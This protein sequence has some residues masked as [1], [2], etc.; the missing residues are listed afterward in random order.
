MTGYGIKTWKSIAFPGILFISLAAFLFADAIHQKLDL[1]SWIKESARI[2]VMPAEDA[3]QDTFTQALSQL[4]AMGAENGSY[5]Y[6]IDTNLQTQSVDKDISVRGISAAMIEGTV[7]S[8]EYY[9]DE[10]SALSAVI[11]IP[12]LATI[13]GAD[14]KS[15]QQSELKQEAAQWI[16]H[17]LIIGKSATKISCVVDDSSESEAVFISIPA[18]ENFIKNQGE[19]PKASSYC[20]EV[21][22]LGS[23]TKIQDKLSENGISTTIDEKSLTDWRLKSAGIT[24][25]IIA[26]CIAVAAAMCMILLSA[27]LVSY[28]ESPKPKRVYL[29]RVCTVF[30]IGIIA[31]VMVDR[32]VVLFVSVK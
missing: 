24:C 15:A 22:D 3:A 2:Y 17:T 16:G 27:R 6:D 19:T 26:G 1:G 30:V 23:I 18:A 21:S 28:R 29:A 31:G 11:N 20:V 14:L 8:G 13:S 25:R 32:L 4:E 12:M 10:S 5:V 7:I 9:L